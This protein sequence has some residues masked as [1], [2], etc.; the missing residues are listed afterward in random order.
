MTDYATKS[1]YRIV[2]INYLHLKLKRKPTEKELFEEAERCNVVSRI[3]W[4]NGPT[5]I[6]LPYDQRD[7]AW[8]NKYDADNDYWNGI[9]R[10]DDE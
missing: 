4:P 10:R 3:N 8:H 9:K 2:L 1:L 5:A 7:D 6:E